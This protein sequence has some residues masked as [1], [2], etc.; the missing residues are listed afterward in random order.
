MAEQKKII[1]NPSGKKKCKAKLKS[2]K[3]CGSWA[4]KGG[5]VCR[6]HGGMAPQVKRKARER[7]EDAQA[8]ITLAKAMKEFSL[9]GAANPG[10]VLLQE[11]TH[12]WR[13]ASWL[14]A[15]V[16]D[17]PEQDAAGVMKTSEKYDEETGAWTYIYMAGVNVWVRLY[18]EWTDRAAKMAK[19]ALDAGIAERQIKIMEQQAS[20][21]AS[22]MYGI[23]KELGVDTGADDTLAVVRRHMMELETVEVID[24]G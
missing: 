4:I 19:M 5:E 17:L 13:T 10:M 22:A 15:K 21:F 7:L 18:A 12:A 14:R 23:L 16:A 2:G 8:R 3:G 20:L 24:V 9:E 6:M 11:L 1:G